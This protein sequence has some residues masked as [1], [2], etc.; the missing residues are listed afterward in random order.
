M[1]P[2]L[3]ARVRPGRCPLV[4]RTGCQWVPAETVSTR[5]VLVVADVS[6][7]CGCR[8]S[9][10]VDECGGAAVVGSSDL[11]RHEVAAVSAL[12]AEVSLIHRLY[13]HFGEVHLDRIILYCIRT[14]LL[15]LA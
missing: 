4:P 2:L 5:R 15:V 12:R 7:H 13:R 9:G 8:L 1:Y 3:A 10:G 11:R 14:E 6:G